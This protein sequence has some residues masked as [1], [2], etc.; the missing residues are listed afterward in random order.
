MALGSD[1]Q[2]MYFMS[3][4]FLND[5]TNGVRVPHFQLVYICN[6]THHSHKKLVKLCLEVNYMWWV[7]QDL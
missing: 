3:T 4:R 6:K 5:N 2:S 7:N 1:R